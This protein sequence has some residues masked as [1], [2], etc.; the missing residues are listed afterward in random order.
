MTQPALTSL[1]DNISDLGVVIPPT[2]GVF[3]HKVDGPRHQE[4]QEQ[5]GDAGQ[6]QD[7]P[8]CHGG[9][10]GGGCIT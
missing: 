2:A 4:A 5:H 3:P 1:R 6:S 9:G 10:G 8:E 7:D